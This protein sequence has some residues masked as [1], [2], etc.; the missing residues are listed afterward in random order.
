MKRYRMLPSDQA[1]YAP[2]LYVVQYRDD[3]LGLWF[4]VGDPLS[5]ADALARLRDLRANTQQDKEKK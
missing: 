4:D 1:G 2:G 5:H 3:S